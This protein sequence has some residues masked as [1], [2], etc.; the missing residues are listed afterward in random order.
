MRFVLFVTGHAGR[1]SFTRLLAGNVTTSASHTGMRIVQ[2]E[3]GAIMIEL[4]RHELHDVGFASLVLAVATLTLRVGNIRQVSVE[5][6]A[7][8]HIGSNVFMAVHAQRRLADTICAV[9]TVGALAFE[10]GV[11][12]SDLAGHQQRF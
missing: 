2:R 8:L 6:T 7:L 1:G 9:M 11:S 12:I 10:L 3:V 5:T 4:R